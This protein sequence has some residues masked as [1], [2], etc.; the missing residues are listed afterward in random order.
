LFHGTSALYVHPV[1]S[2][3]RNCRKITDTTCAGYFFEVKLL[4]QSSKNAGA[5]GYGEAF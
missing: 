5:A 4:K 1:S 3:V 2:L